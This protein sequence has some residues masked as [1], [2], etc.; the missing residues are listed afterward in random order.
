ML[1]KFITVVNHKKIIYPA[2]NQNLHHHSQKKCWTAKNIE[3]NYGINLSENGRVWEVFANLS[4]LPIDFMLKSFSP[5]SSS[6]IYGNFNNFMVKKISSFMLID[7][8]KNKSAF[9][10][11]CC[12]GVVWMINRRK[13]EKFSMAL[14][15]YC[16]LL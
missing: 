13:N 1:K 2:T 6:S 16:E 7:F 5:S 12:N 14:T 9:K 3:I 8:I 11:C 15:T 10:C 4:I